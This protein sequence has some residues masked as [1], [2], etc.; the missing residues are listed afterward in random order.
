MNA[1][2]DHRDQLTNPSNESTPAVPSRSFT[3]AL[4]LLELNAISDQPSSPNSD[5]NHHE[6]IDVT[7]NNKGDQQQKKSEQSPPSICS[8]NNRMNIAH[9]LLHRTL[10]AHGDRSKLL[11][12]FPQKN[13]NSDN[14]I[15]KT[16]I[17]QRIQLAGSSRWSICHSAALAST[18]STSTNT[19]TSY[20]SSYALEFDFEGV[21]LACASNDRGVVQLYDFDELQALD[22]RYWNARARAR[23][24]VHDSVDN[25]GADTK[26]NA[27][28]PSGRSSLPPQQLE[29]VI[30]FRTSNKSICSIKWDPTNEEHLAV[31]FSSSGDVHVYDVGVAASALSG[32]AMGCDNVVRAPPHICLKSAQS[33]CCGGSKCLLFTTTKVRTSVGNKSTFVS[34]LLVGYSDGVVRLWSV[35]RVIHKKA[36]SKILW[37]FS[38]FHPSNGFSNAEAIVDMALLGGDAKSRMKSYYNGMNFKRTNSNPYSGL[39][40]I[41]GARGSLMLIDIECCT[42]K[43]FST[44]LTPTPLRRWSIPRRQFLVRDRMVHLGDTS[45]S[46]IQKLCVWPAEYAGF[47][48]SNATIDRATSVERVLQDSAVSLITHCGWVLDFNLAASSRAKEVPLRV[49]HRIDASHHSYS[50]PICQIGNTSVLCMASH[51]QRVSIG[52][53]RADGHILVYQHEADSDP[54]EAESR[55]K[56]TLVDSGYSYDNNV[57]RSLNLQHKPSSIAAH[58]GGDWIVVGYADGRG[59]ELIRMRGGKKKKARKDSVREAK[60][61]EN[62]VMDTDMQVDADIS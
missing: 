2:L 26:S 46:G 5:V 32:S 24:R 30:K 40:L 44:S 39:L 9:V 56:I 33:Q 21:L 12:A 27:N 35:P 8:T 7:S 18:S 59:L 51:A 22:V 49:V 55:Q 45:I 47:S 37:E 57:L 42:K 1:Q 43:T 23:T 25:E 20:G 62:G 61:C 4:D 58:P 60:D 29:P 16:N 36:M 31:A 38:A 11:H 50:R 52:Q 19:A 41:A 48:S 53:P 34:R 54:E 17:R 6:N 15:S 14:N 28:M 3:T 10:H 13:G